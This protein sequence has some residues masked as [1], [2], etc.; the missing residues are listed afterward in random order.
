MP[1]SLAATLQ[2]HPELQ[3]VLSEIY[4]QM[5]DGFHRS[6]FFDNIIRIKTNPL[7]DSSS[8]AFLAKSLDILVDEYNNDG[9][10]E[11]R[12]EVSDDSSTEDES[13]I[14]SRIIKCIFESI[15]ELYRVSS[16]IRRP[17]LTGRY[18]RSTL[19]S[20][21]LTCEQEY[22]RVRQKLLLWQEQQK[23]KT[24]QDQARHTASQIVR[25]FKEETA[26]PE[27]SAN[28]QSREEISNQ[29]EVVLSRRLAASNIKRRRQLGYWDAY[30][31]QGDPE[32]LNPVDMKLTKPASTAF[33]F[34]TVARSAI[35][36]D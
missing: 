17:R 23:D 9:D 22:E 27:F 33:T 19:P 5:I 12:S 14:V 36:P 29:Q 34:S 24:L 18:L 10:S 21:D 7:V 6:R 4:E 11:T 20:L 31:Y 8:S 25:A 13:S 3:G 2:G 15:E 35:F 28:R 32:T 26:T 16:L 30:P 1:D